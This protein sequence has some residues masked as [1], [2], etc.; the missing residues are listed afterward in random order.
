MFE[1]CVFDNGQMINPNLSDYMIP[2]LLDI[3][4]QMSSHP[5]ES[6]D[7]KADIHG[8]G[9]MT[10]PVIAPA[11]RNA[12]FRA[13]GARIYDLPMTAE[14]VYRAIHENTDAEV[15]SGR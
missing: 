9:E 11:V 10:V 5:L 2:S 3:P 15:G 1:E 14:R 12:I 8:V 4:K 6:D 7:P 13:T